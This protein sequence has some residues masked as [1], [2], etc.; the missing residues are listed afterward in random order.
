MTKDLC[1]ILM[2]IS[3][4]TLCG[5][6]YF[7]AGF[8]WGIKPPETAFE[9]PPGPPIYQQG[10]R[11]GCESGYKGY[12][13]SFNKL[14]GSWKQDPELVENEMYYRIWKDAYLYCANYAMIQD[15]HGLGSWR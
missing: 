12:G 5:C 1:K 13:S 6:T 10:F 3:I 15:E 2:L 11:E 14:F 8:G 9:P 4:T 7:H